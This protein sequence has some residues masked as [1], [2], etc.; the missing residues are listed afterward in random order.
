V[1]LIKNLEEKNTIL[2]EI[3]GVPKHNIALGRKRQFTEQN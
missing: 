1:G 2:W 3:N